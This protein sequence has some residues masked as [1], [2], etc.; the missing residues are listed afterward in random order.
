MPI[1]RVC[2]M[3][4]C[5]ADVLAGTPARAS[6]YHLDLTL[7]T[8]VP[9]QVGGR[10]TAEFPYRLRLS[11]SLGVMPSPYIKLVNAIVVSAGGYTQDTGDALVATLANSLVWRT[12]LG[13]RPLKKLGLYFEL[14][15][16]VTFL[17]G[18]VSGETILALATGTKPPSTSGAATRQ[19]KARSTLHMLDVEIGYELFLVK[20]HLVLRF[21]LGYSG[22]M[23]ASTSIK[24]DFSVL[25]PAAW[26]IF[27]DGMA[28]ALDDSVKSY[29]HTVTITVGIGYRFF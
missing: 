24:P 10:I 21:A 3:V 20:R 15:Y 2:L 27:T 11:T 13:W 1:A 22:V 17:G 19:Y 8:D 14:G 26:K 5:L 23:G 9:V 6:S 25:S 16:G 18:G 12:H 7:H 29:F 28:R 4:I